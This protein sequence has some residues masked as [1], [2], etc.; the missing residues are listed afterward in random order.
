MKV[1]SS[2][3]TR[4]KSTAVPLMTL[5][6]LSEKL[7]PLASEIYTLPKGVPLPLLSRNRKTYSSLV[8]IK[9]KVVVIFASLGKRAFFKLVNPL[10]HVAE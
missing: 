7:R 10:L 1:P 5:E 6:R 2:D 8:S 9:V 3:V 4:S